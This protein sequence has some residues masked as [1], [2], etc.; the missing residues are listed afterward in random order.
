VSA[1]VSPGRVRLRA[2]VALTPSGDGT[3]VTESITVESPTVLRRYVLR[4]ARAVQLKRAAELTR[5][6]AA[7]TG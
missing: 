5:R 7:A 4:R 1:V 2:A 3:E 6:M